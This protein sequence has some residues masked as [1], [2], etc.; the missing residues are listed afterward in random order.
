MSQDQPKGENMDATIKRCTC[1]SW[2]YGINICE[3]CRKLA[4]G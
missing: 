2:I 4:I 1:G 3:V